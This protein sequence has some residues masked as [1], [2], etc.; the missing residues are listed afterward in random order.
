MVSN[1]EDN[2]KAKLTRVLE[3][4]PARKPEQAKIGEVVRFMYNPGDGQSAYWLQGPLGPRLDK[5]K[6]AQKSN[7]ARNRFKVTKLSIV[8]YW[9]EKGTIPETVTVN[10]SR[11]TAWSLGEEIELDTTEE[12]EAFVF[13]QGEKCEQMMR[14]MKQQ[15][16]RKKMS[17]MRHQTVLR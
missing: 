11:N 10:L 17:K 15:M 1:D 13:E 16:T 14:W 12:D 9:G 7:F 2:E 6:V 4:V 8:K 3:F 5:Y